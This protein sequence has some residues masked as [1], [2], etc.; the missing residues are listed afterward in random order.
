MNYHSYCDFLPNIPIDLICSLPEIETYENVF[1]NKEV[2]E[3]Y[4]SYRSPN[5]LNN[6]IQ[7]YFDY[8]I[9]VRYQV[10]KKDLPIHIDLGEED[11]KY[12]YLITT[13]GEN[14]TTRFWDSCNDPKKILYEVVTEQ[15]KWHH[16]NIKVPHQVINV[17][18][19]RVS[20]TVK[21]KTV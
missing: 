15:A 19:P 5:Y 16:L 3:T 6:F 13:G 18:S 17:L 1:P 11:M 2:V 4:A 7:K 14:V 8:P 12:N 20:I 21:R 9:V 10:I